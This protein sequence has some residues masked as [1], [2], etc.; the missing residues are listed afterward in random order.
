MIPGRKFHGMMATISIVSLF[1]L[2]YACWSDTNLPIQS[3]PALWQIM[4]AVL[5]VCG[6]HLCIEILSASRKIFRRFNVEKEGLAT[7]LAAVPF[8][9]VYYAKRNEPRSLKNMY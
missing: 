7:L 9:C 1:T 5:V 3:A 4:G 6:L 8:Q 2:L